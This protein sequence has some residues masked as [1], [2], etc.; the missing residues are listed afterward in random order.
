MIFI[1]RENNG[2]NCKQNND[3]ARAAGRRMLMI[4]RGVLVVLA[5]LAV[6]KFERDVGQ[7]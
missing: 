4:E 2:E 6:A 5:Q 3:A 7:Y 1:K